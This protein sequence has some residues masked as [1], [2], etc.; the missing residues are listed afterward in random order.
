M[1]E[2]LNHDAE[3]RAISHNSINNDARPV[4]IARLEPGFKKV[5]FAPLEQHPTFKLF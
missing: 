1:R 2:I 4:D 3:F 5:V